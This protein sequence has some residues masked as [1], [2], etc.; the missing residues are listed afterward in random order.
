MQIVPK[1]EKIP[2]KNVEKNQLTNVEIYVLRRDHTEIPEVDAVLKEMMI[3]GILSDSPMER[4][5]TMK[6]V[7]YLRQTH[8]MVTFI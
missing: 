6:D 5:D 3:D 1:K 7:D 8:R 2:Y 4:G